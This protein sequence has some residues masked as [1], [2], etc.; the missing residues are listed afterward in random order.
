MDY[1]TGYLWGRAG[2]ESH[3]SILLRQMRCKNRGVVI[4]C[5]CEGDDRMDGYVTGRLQEWFQERTVMLC[6]KKIK[7]QEWEHELYGLM[8]EADDEIQHFAQRKDISA[9][10]SL[11]GILAVDERFW[12]LQR[13]S[14]S[15][16]LLN[17]SFLRPHIRLLAGEQKFGEYETKVVPGRLQRGLGI[18]LCTA[19]FCEG[20]DK[21]LIRDCLNTND[22]QSIMQI[23][24][25]LKELFCEGGRRGA[26]EDGSAVFVKTL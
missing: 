5:V 1:L 25:R 16:Y 11:S 10:W 17:Q 9:E 7:G 2:I 19:G 21:G 12:L 22:T 13:G 24:K 20:I 3:T 15:V 26:K 14:C 4:A 8:Q 6:R 23:E 18:L